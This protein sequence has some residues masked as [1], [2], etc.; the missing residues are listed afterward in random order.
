MPAVHVPQYPKGL[1]AADEGDYYLTDWCN[2]WDD[3]EL[4]SVLDLDNAEQK[5]EAA[6]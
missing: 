2:W 3:L 4:R 5:E 1:F 6:Q